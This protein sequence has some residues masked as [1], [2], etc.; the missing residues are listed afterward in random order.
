MYV[1]NEPI[2]VAATN[3]GGFLAS[4]KTISSTAVQTPISLMG[5]GGGGRKNEIYVDILERLTVLFNSNGYVMNSSIDGS[6]QMKSYLSG[7]P[8]L[9][10]AL[11]E[12]LV[13]GKDSTSGYGGQFVLDDCNFHECVNLDDFETGRTIALIPPQGEF[14]VMNYRITGEFRTPFRVFPMIEETSGY[15]V[16]LVLRVKA[17]IPEKNHGSNVVIRFPVPKNVATVTPEVTNPGLTATAIGS[18]VRG[19]ASLASGLGALPTGNVHGI[20]NQT[21]EYNS[22]DKEVVWTITKFQGGSEHTLN[23]KI[24]L[25]SP[26]GPSLRKELGPISM[27]F[28]IPMYHVSNL[29]VRPFYIV[30]LYCQIVSPI[31]LFAGSLPSYC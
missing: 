31:C 29:Q 10:L 21:A 19:A 18:G 7:N 9:R 14:V 30:Y 8:G 22:K 23:T 4:K 17:E 26:L 3:A 5:I 25:S 13:V 16:N 28:E 15:N 24:T 12:D 20:T 27:S 2:A 6:I 11:N 1:H